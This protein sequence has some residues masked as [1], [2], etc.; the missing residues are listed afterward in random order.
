MRHRWSTT[1]HFKKTH[2]CQSID[3]SPLSSILYPI[4]FFFFLSYYQQKI[5]IGKNWTT[6]C[7]EVQYLKNSEPWIQPKFLIIWDGKNPFQKQAITLLPTWK[8]C[9]L[10]P[11]DCW[12]KKENW[13]KINF[14]HCFF[15][16][17]TVT[18]R[19]SLTYLI[20]LAFFEIAN[21]NFLRLT[22]CL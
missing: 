2:P 22:I 17:I 21:C 4:I 6:K 9:R 13:W 15:I 18:L 8:Q 10:R 19:L 7:E 14:S 16:V 3:Q 1:Y 5:L 11:L 12:I 20:K